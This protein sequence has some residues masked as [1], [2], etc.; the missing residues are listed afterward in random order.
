MGR[1]WAYLLFLLPA[2]GLAASVEIE[3]VRVADESDRT[4]VVFE[5]NAPVDHLVFTLPDPDRV[6]V[7]LKRARLG[8]S[9][10]A[11]TVG[12]LV[13]RVRHAPRNGNDLRVVLDLRKRARPQTFLLRPN[14]EH[15][16]RLIVDLFP[17]GK[18]PGQ[19]VKSVDSAPQPE[20]RDVIIA[21]DAGH[22][23][24]DPGA[25]GRGGTH[26]KD[27]VLAIA[28]KLAAAFDREPGMRA[29]MVRSDDRFMRLRERMR[30]ARQHRADLFIS[31]HADAYRDTQARG[32]SV[33]VLSERGATSEAARWL[34]DRE[35]AADLVGGVSLDDKDDELAMVLL[36]LSQTATLEASLHV[37]Q[38]IL[39]ELQ[40]MGVVHRGGVERASFAVLKSPDIPS[41][42]VETAFIS[43]PAEER[44]LRDGKHQQ[45]LAQVI[46]RGVRAYFRDHAPPDTWLAARRSVVASKGDD[47][48]G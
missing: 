42:L 15:G 40:A 29:V 37:A 22:G 31:I 38:S 2:V 19:P 25:L 16:H 44:K 34:A 5:L 18:A 45:R 32:S 47:A 35:N 24:V 12:K 30:V 43:N 9:F 21:I 36:D 20:A 23:G 3:A 14:G 27:V 28:R 4:R 48:G 6:V 39:T 13:E 46:L 41:V 8:S 33:Y 1:F 11:P 10:D 7:D 26:E 17:G